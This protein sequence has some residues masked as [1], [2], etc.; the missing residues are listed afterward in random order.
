MPQGTEPDLIYADLY[1]QS[2]QPRFT[3]QDVVR[4][5]WNNVALTSACWQSWSP[6]CVTPRASSAAYALTVSHTSATHLHLDQ[7]CTNTCD[8]ATH[9]MRR[10]AS[11]ARAVVP[12]VKE[13]QRHSVSVKHKP[14]ILRACS[15]RQAVSARWARVVERQLSTFTHSV[16]RRNTTA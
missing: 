2:F 7:G 16:A 8:V 15:R 13:L 12:E 14:V 3:W 1:I 11:I 4:P 9:S 5:A 6:C 10:G